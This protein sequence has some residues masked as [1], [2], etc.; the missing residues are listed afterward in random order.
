MECPILKTNDDLSDEHIARR[1][2][3]KLLLEYR[4]T[5]FLSRERAYII[6]NPNKQ[7]TWSFND[8]L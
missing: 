8:H 6:L 3:A 2:Q 1:N 7:L 4:K 5:V